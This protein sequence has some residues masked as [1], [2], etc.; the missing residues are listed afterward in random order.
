[1]LELSRN[2]TSTALVHEKKTVFHEPVLGAKT[3]GMAA[4][5]GHIQGKAA[6]KPTWYPTEDS[7]YLL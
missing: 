5:G 1:M 2:H 3:M 7:Q 4:V 6:G